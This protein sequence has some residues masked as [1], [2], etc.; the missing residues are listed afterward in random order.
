VPV[1]NG[2]S[3]SLG[4]LSLTFLETRMLHWPD[5]MFSYL[6]RS[7]CF[8]PGCLRHAPCHQP[9]LAEEIDESVLEWEGAKYF[10]NILLP[11]SS[12]VLKLIDKVKS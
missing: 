6:P 7:A 5:N 12:L 11:Y 1:K 4:N 8:L 9:A 10:A 2:E 3:L